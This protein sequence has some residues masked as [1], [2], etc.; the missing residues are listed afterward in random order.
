MELFDEFFAIIQEFKNNRI[1]YCVIGG[2]AMAFHDEPRFT[3]DI[4]ILSIPSQ[5]EKIK[6]ALQAL[7][8]E[9][10]AEPWDLLKTNTTIYRF[11]KI[12]NDEYMPVD[13][14]IGK[15]R[16]HKDVITNASRLKTGIGFIR[17]ATR[18]DLIKLKLIRNSDQDKVDI[19]KL[20]GGQ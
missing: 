9:M 2:I 10:S 6:E 5:F 12:C 20:E 4:D 3:K 11:M 17:I 8:Y 13:I 7:D 18:G 1:K 16:F 19:K 14:L 15:D